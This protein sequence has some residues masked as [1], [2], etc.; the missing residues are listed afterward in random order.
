M[1][2]RVLN[3]IAAIRAS[4]HDSVIV[5]RYGGCY[6]FFQILHCVFPTAKAYFAD[7]DKDHVLT[8]IGGR[9]YDIKGETLE[10]SEVVLLNKQEHEHWSAVSSGQRL[11]QILAKYNGH[12]KRIENQKT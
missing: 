3:F 2:K 7:G 6:G 10:T 8:K 4:F 5:Y 11:E 1:H 9:W 12:N